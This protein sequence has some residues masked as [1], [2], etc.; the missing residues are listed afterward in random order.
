MGPAEERLK[1]FREEQR[2]ELMY[3]KLQKQPLLH[4]L[5]SLLG[6]NHKSLSNAIVGVN[7]GKN[8]DRV[9]GKAE[10]NPADDYVE[11]LLRL[12][13]Y[14]DYLVIN[15]SS[16]NTPH[17]RELQQQKELSIILTQVFAA[18]ELLNKRVKENR[19]ERMPETTIGPPILIKI[20][21]DITEQ[22]KKDIAE[23]ALQHE[24]DGIIIS[25]TTITRPL[26]SLL[27]TQYDPKFVLSPLGA[28]EPS[29]PAPVPASSTSYRFS[30][31]ASST[32]SSSPPPSS[33]SSTTSTSTPSSNS[34]SLSSLSSLFRPINEE[35]I[36]MEAGGLS[37]QPLF[38]PSTKLLGEMYELTK[39][40]IPLIGVGGISSGKDAFDKI[41]AGASLVQLYTGLVYQG[42]GLVPQIKRELLECLDRHKF[43]T[44]EEAVGSAH[45][46][47]TTTTTQA[48][49]GMK[50]V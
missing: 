11:L 6:K 22:Q 43:R 28:L 4:R 49:G 46:T 41:R 40:K 33:S 5:Q 36:A 18:R 17:L 26:R 15:V 39:G 12:G 30:S 7:L 47:T 25:N 31:P 21:P 13:Q 42:P 14:A 37:G 50:R 48:E 3:G 23:L 19:A 32:S 24:V 27:A 9:T 1:K 2:D 20:S 10:D 8:K 29:G 45:K 34:P 44:I 38:Q 35:E 16:P